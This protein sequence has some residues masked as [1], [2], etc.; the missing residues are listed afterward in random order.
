MGGNCAI[1]IGLCCDL[2]SFCFVQ[3]TQ[4]Q[5]HVYSPFLPLLILL[6]TLHQVSWLGYTWIWTKIKLSFARQ[7]CLVLT[8]WMLFSVRNRKAEGFIFLCVNTSLRHTDLPLLR[9][10]LKSWEHDQID[11]DKRYNNWNNRWCVYLALY[12][13]L[14]VILLLWKMYGHSE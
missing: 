7:W 11:V 1:I 13:H 8:C 4:P 10:C 2:A 14:Y 12:M 3:L 6:I 5:T 9:H